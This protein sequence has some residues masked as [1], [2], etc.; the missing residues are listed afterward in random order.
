MSA[1][2]LT[3]LLALEAKPQTCSSLSTSDVVID[4][5]HWQA[6]VDFV[7]A[8]SAGIAAVILKATQGSDWST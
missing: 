5:G 1:L 8:K 4:L 3:R 7:K 2:S 6:P